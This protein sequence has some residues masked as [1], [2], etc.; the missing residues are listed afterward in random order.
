MDAVIGLLGLAALAACIFAWRLSQG[1]I[2]ITRL[3]Q[4]EQPLLT[5]P[6]A[7]L[8]IGGAALAWE[9]F[10]TKGQPLDVRVKD[11]AIATDDGSL[12]A[13]MPSGQV[14]LSIGQLLLGRIVPQT[15]MID[16]ATVHMQRRKN[17]AW[18][19]DLGNRSAAPSGGPGAEAMLQELTRPA[20]PGD[21]LPWLSQL[22]KVQ[23]R[24]AK[25]SISDAALGVLWEAP[26]AEA[27]LKRLSS[28]GVAGHARL[29]LAVG[30]VHATL[31][32]KA[33]LKADGTHITASTTPLSP[34]A[35]A[36]I[37]P[38]F[39][40][41]DAVNAPVAFTLDATLGPG[42]APQ[43]AQL[44]VLA[45]A[46]TMKAGTGIV[47]LQS[48]AA[49]FSAKP[50]E[51]RLDS[52]R[53]AFAAAKG[54]QSPPVLTGTASAALNAGKIQASF[55][56]AVDRLEFADLA[57]YWPEGTGGGSRPW[58][59]ENVIAGHAHDAHVEGTINA[60]TDFSGLQVASLS[61]GMLADDVTLF[62]LKPIPPL[63]H[64]HAR[65]TIEGPDS[66]RVTMDSAEQGQL[67]LTSGSQIRI[68]RLQEAHQFGDIEAH[69]QGN[70]ADAL[71][72][73]N[74][75]RLKLL[76]RAGLDFAD[77]AGQVTATIS[78]HLPLED[79]VT[80]A[81]IHVGATGTM[82]DVHLSRIAADRDLERAQLA[83][84]VDDDGMTITG[85]GIYAG[86]PA[87]LVLDMDFRNGPANQV[88][89]HIVAN[90]TASP[91][92]LL[93]ADLLP[94]GVVRSFAAGTTAVHAEYSGLRDNTATLLVDADL[95]GAQL[96]TPLGWQ[97][98]TGPQAKAGARLSIDH[99]R[100]VGIDQ[101]HAEGPGLAITSHATIEAGHTRALV[102]DRIELGRTRAHGEIGFP[103]APTSR[104][105]VSL[106]GPMLDLSSYLD[107]PQADRANNVPA[108][109]D[110]TPDQPED[111]KPGQPWETDL[112]FDRVQL[113][114]GKTLRPF[115][116]TAASDGLHVARAQADAG[117]P[118]ELSASIVP[119]R[120]IRRVSVISSDA[121]VFLQ[122]MGVADNLVGGHLRLE[123]VFADN[124]PGDPLTGTATLENFQLRSA[125]AIGRLLQAMTLYGV[126]DVLRGPGLHFSKMVA[127]FRWQRRV[128]HLENA[129][130]FSPSLGLTA[131][132]DID[133][134]N[135]TAN[136]TGTVVPAYFFNQLLGNLPL[137]GKVFS[138]EKGGGVFAA[139][140]SVKGKL[141]D[142]KVGV[143]PLSA[144]TPGFL[145]EG[146]GLL[147][148]TANLPKK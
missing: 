51:L 62:W 139:R 109:P 54:H 9:G 63:T 16:G 10:T 22:R 25:F 132:G 43:S 45:G 2:D 119:S 111:Q 53:I 95:T 141:A 28:G 135:R 59:V 55:Q 128:L 85:N 40:F 93:Q 118:G 65:L 41:L 29:D 7:H 47:A 113:A 70:L 18:R 143:N 97:K 73:L 133:L 13:Q 24:D 5:G 68:T 124:Q 108:T 129:R 125:P 36:K 86:I 19:L 60:H 122:A 33:E 89:Q 64:G 145:R 130:A 115:T 77:A 57:D 101:L 138:P 98:E 21:N 114:K 96:K 58:M 123:G 12:Q 52:L 75:P 92:Q 99:G 71:A 26:H 35:L 79:R 27:D 104:L 8:S 106:S 39:G 11:V 49:R 126:T 76:S 20:R 6:G 120:G 140:Y 94:A 46:G 147:A 84:K 112:N 90:G 142:P 15:I 107:E 121:G 116:L 31:S 80:I 66:L 50:A 1:P 14:T 100:L 136:V 3:V 82:T 30:D 67:Q 103:A 48:A 131:Q 105:T 4:R 88:L 74:H 127:P 34:A 69:L 148:P 78:V 137:I 61:G 87:N 81:D 102:L 144:L 56:F 72:L 17:G 146:F 37:A 23:I 44:D 91:T 42:L 134:K 38:Q 32:A 117:A 83:L 110:D